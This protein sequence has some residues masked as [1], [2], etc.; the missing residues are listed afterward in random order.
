MS[1]SGGIRLCTF[2]ISKGSPFSFSDGRNP[3]VYHNGGVTVF[4]SYVT[5]A[6]LEEIKKVVD[7]MGCEISVRETASEDEYQKLERKRLAGVTSRNDVWPCMKCID[8]TWFDPAQDDPC[9]ARAWEP[10]MVEAMLEGD[11]AQKDLASCPVM[12]RSN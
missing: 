6:Y 3:T 12:N 4:H 2:R 9:G 1:E 10:S 5:D 11:K 7:S 8:C